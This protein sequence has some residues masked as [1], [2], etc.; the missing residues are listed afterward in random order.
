MVEGTRDMDL[1]LW[2]IRKGMRVDISHSM[3]LNQG[4][5]RDQ[6]QGRRTHTGSKR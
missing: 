5:V 2:K 6:R 4:W 3:S 1:H